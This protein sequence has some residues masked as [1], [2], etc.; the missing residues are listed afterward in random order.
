[1]VIRIDP[2]KMFKWLFIGLL[3]WEVALVILDAFMSEF[4][5]VDI[6]AAQRLFNITREDALPNFFSS[7]QLLSVGLVVLLITLTVR[8]NLRGTGS[9]VARGWGGHCWTIYLRWHR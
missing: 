7:I 2:A 1:M 5:V 8:E 4:E 6:G 9:L 3:A